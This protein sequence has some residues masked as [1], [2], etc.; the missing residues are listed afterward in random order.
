[1]KWQRPDQRGRGGYDL[2]AGNRIYL[3]HNSTTVIDPAVAASMGALEGLPLNPSSAH[4]SGRRAAALFEGAQAN[5]ARLV[6]ARAEEIVVTSGGTESNVLAV[7]GT[8][9]SAARRPGH[10]VVSAIE[11]PSVIEAARRLAE[12]GAGV[13]FVAPGSD[14]AV[15]PAA[16][17]DA[18]LPE[19]VLAAMMLVNNETGVIQDVSGLARFARPL[20][21]TVFSDAVQ[22]AAKL[23]I[24]ADDLGVDLLSV[25]GHKF[26]G[27]LGTG[28]LYVRDG[29]RLKPVLAGGT[30]QRGLRPG[31]ENVPGA[32]GLAVACRDAVERIGGDT[33]R[34]RG[35]RDALEREVINSIDDVV[36]NGRIRPR[37]CNTSSLTV[38]GVDAGVLL[39]ILD[40]D[41]IAVSAGSA[42][43]ALGGEPSH[44]LTAM[45]LPARDAMSTIRVSFGRE[46]SP[47]DVDRFVE[48]LR[49]AVRRIRA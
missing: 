19:T 35:L 27:P 15:D 46:N 6:G 26:H 23:P 45:G 2:D 39:A 49:R 48:T 18:F 44:V 37:V 17:A 13:T 7:F 40:L 4:A 34:M 20:G 21:I 47:G 42:C 8:T 43:A 9:A 38:R 33:E 31:T 41:G 28:F 22:A 5:M 11:H 32:V 36:I 10:L 1:M 12:S 14:G 25:S 3:D 24:H 16:M 29:T 30:Q